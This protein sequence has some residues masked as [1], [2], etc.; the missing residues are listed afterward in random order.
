MDE[1]FDTTTYLKGIVISM[2][3]V[4]HYFQNFGTDYFGWVRGYAYGAVSIFFVLAGYGA[5][6]SAKKHFDNNDGFWWNAAK[7]YLDRALRIFPLYWAALL[8]TPYP[9]IL[10]PGWQTVGIFLG[11]PFLQAPG[12]FWFVPAIIQCYLLAP[13]LY[14]ALRKLGEKIYIALNGAAIAIFLTVTFIF[15]SLNIN[16]FSD[17]VIRSNSEVIFYKRFFLANVILFSLGLAMVPLLARY[18]RMMTLAKVTKKAVFPASILAFMLLLFLTR[19]SY[20]YIIFDGAKLHYMETALAAVFLISAVALCLTAIDTRP[21]LPLKK[22]VIIA[23]E[24]SFPLYLF[25]IAF[26]LGLDRFRLLKN[27]DLRSMM[28]MA[29]L[30]P[31]L[32]GFAVGMGSVAKST[33]GS[34]K[35]FFGLEKK[36]V[37]QEA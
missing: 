19:S 13:V 1:S 18:K 6:H 27:N 22:I 34:L 15:L 35:I 16:K 32:L 10:K 29:A 12:V 2:V 14:L 26:F 5:F 37:E 21:P 28:I 8:V 7:Y 25:H 17:T 33:A 30:L 20:S 9:E 36:P 31:I 4:T 23:G 3:L 11:A 24:A